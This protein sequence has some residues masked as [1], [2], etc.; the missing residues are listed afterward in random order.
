MRSGSFCFCFL[1][2]QF[3]V[4]HLQE[5]KLSTTLYR[6][7]LGGETVDRCTY[8]VC[9]GFSSYDGW[10]DTEAWADTLCF[11]FGEEGGGGVVYTRV[12]SAL[13]VE[14]HLQG[15]PRCVCVSYTWRIIYLL[16]S[17]LY[18]IPLTEYA[19]VIPRL[20]QGIPRCLCFV[21]LENNLLAVEYIVPLTEF[22][23]C[24]YHTKLKRAIYLSKRLQSG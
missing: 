23:L 24:H 15:I 3:F 10:C 4:V 2:A 16:W 17:M 12:L 8:G 9:P 11:L 7:R 20:I 18:I 19:H 1:F 6:D 13:S 21:H 22:A 14:R 5:Q